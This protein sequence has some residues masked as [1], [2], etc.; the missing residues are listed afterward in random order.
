MAP[1]LRTCCTRTRL[2]LEERRPETDERVSAQLEEV[3]TQILRPTFAAGGAP[4]QRLT[5]RVC[6]SW[7]N[8]NPETAND[9]TAGGIPMCPIKRAKV[10]NA[11]YGLGI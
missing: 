1:Q 3:P 11:A 2:Q 8:A 9:V 7:W 4:T 5:S 6:C 10:P